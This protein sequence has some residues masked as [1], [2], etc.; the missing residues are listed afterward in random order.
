MDQLIK[1]RAWLWL[2]KEKLLLGVLVLVLCFRVYK[3]VYPPEVKLPDPPVPPSPT[4][5]GDV[6]PGAPPVMPAL[7]ERIP[8]TGLVKNN[9][10]T[11]YGVDYGKKE[12]QRPELYFLGLKEWADGTWRAQITTNPRFRPKL[13]KEGEEFESFRLERI[14]VEA[15][16]ITVYSQADARS[17]TYKLI[18]R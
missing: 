9:P 6:P 18:E 14:D 15:E 3:V 1:L 13:Y 2:N 11:V 8:S 16:E 5:S 12:E 7:P 17:F 4:W 10:F